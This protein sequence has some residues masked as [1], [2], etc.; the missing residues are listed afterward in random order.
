MAARRMDQDRRNE[1]FRGMLA[2]MEREG[3]LRR[4]TKT[5]SPR[6]ITA[7]CGQAPSAVLCEAVAD[8]D[9]PVVGGLYWTRDR[10]ASA[11]ATNP[12]PAAGVLHLRQR[13]GGHRTRARKAARTAVAS[14]R[15]A[16]IRSANRS[17]SADS[18]S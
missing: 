15:A 18:A 14:L 16:S 9:I 5:I 8:Y 11:L 1:D 4:V 2:R 12:A 7:L 10:L 17:P 6:H 13:V 3:H